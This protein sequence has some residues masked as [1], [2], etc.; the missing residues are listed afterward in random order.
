MNLRDEVSEGMHYRGLRAVEALAGDLPAWKPSHEFPLGKLQ[1]TAWMMHVQSEVISGGGFGR[2]TFAAFLR[3]VGQEL[4]HS[5]LLGLA[6]T[7][8]EAGKL[9][10]D[11]VRITNEA[12]QTCG[13]ADLSRCEELPALMRSLVE[14]E[15][16]GVDGL[17]NAVG[18]K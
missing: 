11:V 6:E 3:Q 9:W 5:Q 1:S 13:D 8:A 12:T 2:R 7:Y 15:Q 18:L 14:H 10:R 16:R 4:N 17:A